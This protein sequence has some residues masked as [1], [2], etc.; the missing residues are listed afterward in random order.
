MRKSYRVFA[1]AFAALLSLCL[2]SLSARNRVENINILMPSP[3]VNA[4]KEQVDQFNK[5]Y[6]GSI[7]LNITRGPLETEAISDLAISSLLLGD[8]PYDALLIDV[9]WLAKYAAAGWLRPLDQWFTQADIDQLVPGAQIGNNFDGHLLRWPFGADIGLLYWRTDLMENAPKTPDELTEIVKN[10]TEEGYV[11]HGFVWQGR[12]YEGL[13]CDYLEVLKG[14]GGDWLSSETGEPDLTSQEAMQ[15]ASWLRSL[16]NNSLTPK[17]VTNFAEQESLQV[18]KSGD[19]ALMRNWPYAWAELQK[20]ESA[21]RGKIGIAP[22]VSIPTEQSRATLGS[23]GF[24]ILNESSHPEATAKA[25]R[26]LTSKQSQRTR[27][28]NNSYTP[29]NI[30]LFRDDELILISSILPELEKILSKAVARPMTPIYAQLSDILQR[31]LN[32]ILT[33]STSVKSGLENAQR[34]SRNLIRATRGIS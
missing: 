21:V 18:F 6:H 29:T 9:T 27:F 20:P 16:I 12:Q 3:F 1:I 22:M 32:A 17:A 13:I 24:S 31:Q 30:S 33:D 14:F 7:Q 28:L 2:N 8:S 15:A 23:W 4:I 26:Y 5:E 19:A 11:N 25:I 34:K 10:L